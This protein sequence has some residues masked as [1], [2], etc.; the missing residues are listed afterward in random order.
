MRFALSEEQVALQRTVEE[1]CAGSV[2]DPGFGST[3][4][5]IA[6]ARDEI[7]PALAELGLVG[8][9]V[10]VELGGVGGTLVDACAVAE[11]LGRS[12]APVPFVGSAIAAAA[13]LT[14]GPGNEPALTELAAGQTHSVLLDEQ[15]RLTD[16][17]AAIAFDWAPDGRG[18]CI[19]EGR[20]VVVELEEPCVLPGVDLLHPLAA[21]TPVETSAGSSPEA[22]RAQAI[23]WTGLA[24]HLLGL[25]AG[26]LAQAVTHAKAREQYGRPIG[27]FQAIQHLCADMLVDVETCRSIVYGAAWSV[28]HGRFEDVEAMAAAAKFSAGSAAI[29]VCEGAIQV[30]G[31]IGVTQEHDAHLRLRSAHLHHAAFGGSDVPLELLA[32]RLLVSGGDRDGSPGVR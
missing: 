27:S 2:S 5:G 20:A 10:P 23:I 1:V 8:V 3:P 29:R 9:L 17:R 7:W 18:V 25:A 15:L 31:G 19:R 11:S 12:L 4:A 26:T 32:G 24:A 13:V 14:R 28:E 30:L 6:G 21:A 22:R 16:G